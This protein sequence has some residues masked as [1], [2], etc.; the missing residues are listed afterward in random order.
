MLRGSPASATRRWSSWAAT[1]EVL[2]VISSSPC[3]LQPVFQAMLE[4]AVRHLR[5]QVWGS[6][7]AGWGGLSCGQQAARLN[8]PK[9]RT[10]RNLRDR[11]SLPDGRYRAIAC[12]RQKSLVDTPRIGRTDPSPAAEYGDAADHHSPRQCSRAHDRWRHRNYR[13]KSVPLPTSRSSWSRTS[14]PRRSSPLRT[15]GC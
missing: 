14:P 13:R 7:P 4:N 2:K 5:G 3:E 10:N 15:R 9:P 11:G 1:S 12:C 6:F 8:L